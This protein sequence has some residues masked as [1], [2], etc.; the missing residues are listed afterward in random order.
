MG[1]LSAVV[2]N[3][4]GDIEHQSFYAAFG[5]FMLD[6][7]TAIAG[8]INAISQIVNEKHFGKE[9]ARSF[10]QLKEMSMAMSY[11]IAKQEFKKKNANEKTLICGNFKKQIL[12]GGWSISKLAHNYIEVLKKYDYEEYKKALVGIE[13]MKK[14]IELLEEERKSLAL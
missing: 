5:A 12:N 9:V 6:K 3:C 14:A 13:A 1:I 10:E 4:I 7:N 2:Q 8:T 11:K